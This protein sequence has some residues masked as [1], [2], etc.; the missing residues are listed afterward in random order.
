MQPTARL[1]QYFYQG[2]LGNF[3]ELYRKNAAE[4]TRKAK[5]M[6]Q[7]M[8]SPMRPGDAA[9]RVVSGNQQAGPSGSQPGSGGTGNMGM[10]GQQS[11]PQ[12]TGS[13]TNGVPSFPMQGPPSPHPPGTPTMHG[14][15][16]AAE[17]GVGQFPAQGSSA[18]ILDHEQDGLG[19]RK[20]ESE[21]ADL[22]RARQKTGMS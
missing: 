19:K 12:S 22:K 9:S 11:N 18:N 5:A 20:L 17:G 8:G 14:G 1:L 21:E 3:E 7:N 6:G 4:Q 15:S 10:M 16:P 2:L 13:P